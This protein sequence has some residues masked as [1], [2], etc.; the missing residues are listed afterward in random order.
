MSDPADDF[1][2][3]LELFEA[4]VRNQDTQSASGRRFSQAM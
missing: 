3:C 2:E 4:F 1:R